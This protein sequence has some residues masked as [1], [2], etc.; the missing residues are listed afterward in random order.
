M[1]TKISLLVMLSLSLAC[2]TPAQPA[3]G[4]R[5]G[6]PTTIRVTHGPMLGRPAADSMSLWFR[7]ERPGPVKVLFGTDR[8]AFDREAV[9][10]TTDITRDNTGI[11]KLDKLQANTRYY[12]SLIHI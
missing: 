12:L 9:L 10:D 3:N 8:N 7:T 5:D 6:L 4:L 2:E 1:K 11:L